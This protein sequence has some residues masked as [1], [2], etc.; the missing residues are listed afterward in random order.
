MRM[1]LTSS[2]SYPFWPWSVWSEPAMILE[3]LSDHKVDVWEA[4]QLALST[5]VLEEPEQRSVILRDPLGCWETLMRCL[6]PQLPKN[7]SDSWAK[8]A[9]G[10]SPEGL[11]HTC[12][13]LKWSALTLLH[14]IDLWVRS[15]GEDQWPILTQNWSSFFMTELSKR[16]RIIS[17]VTMRTDLLELF[18]DSFL[19]RICWRSPWYQSW[20]MRPWSNSSSD[21]ASWWSAFIWSWPTERW[22]SL[23]SWSAAAISEGSWGLDFV[24]TLLLIWTGCWGWASGTVLAEELEAD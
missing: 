23:M 13:L 14:K 9:W 4:K 24:L 22:F 12:H 2:E 6:K 11:M 3:H 17:I 1:N 5:D 8:W 19:D 15:Q 21:G 18:C 16:T 20:R 10:L 7:E